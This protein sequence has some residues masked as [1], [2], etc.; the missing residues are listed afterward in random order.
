MKQLNDVLGLVGARLGWPGILGLV[1]LVSAA[2]FY[3]FALAPQRLRIEDLQRESVQLRQRAKVSEKDVPQGPAD[4]LAAFNGFF[5]P[6][7][8]LPDLLEKIFGAA[9]RQ[10]LVLEQGEYRPL[11]DT[12]GTLMRYQFTLPLRGTY[13]QIRKFVDDALAEVPALALDGIQFERRK[14][15][16]ATVDA[17]VKMV[18]YLGNKS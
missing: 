11:K 9:K 7:K 10:S 18:V 15:G 3:V 6:S 1:L 2:G 5:P 12:V 17:K 16:D 4:K 8:D 14:I 13:P